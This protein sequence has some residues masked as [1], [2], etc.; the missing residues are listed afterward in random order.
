MAPSMRPV[1]AGVAVAIVIA[2]VVAALY[3]YVPFK[4]TG[5]STSSTSVTTQ[6]P[7][8]LQL[9]LSLNSTRIASGGTLGATVSEFNNQATT[10]NVTKADLWKVQGLSLGPCETEGYSIYPFGIAVYQG[11]YSSANVSQGKAMAIYPVVACPLMLRLVTGYLFQPMNDSAVILPSSGALPTSMSVTV[12]VSGEFGQGSL[13]PLAPGVYTV[14]AGD[15]WGSLITMQ[16][17]V[18]GGS[19]SSSTSGSRMNGTL[20]ALV[21]IGPIVPVCGVN[22]TPG[23]AASQYSSIKAVITPSSGGN[24]TL[25]VNWLSDGC[26]VSGRFQAFLAPGDYQLNL[27]NCSFMGCSSSLPKAFT[28]SP[29]Q[30]NTLSVSIDTGIR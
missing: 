4:T 3:V 21:T 7:N 23:P 13:Q 22:A 6:R 29:G 8:G 15:E 2:L 20:S 30:Q 11:A 10:N 12:R 9:R 19:T 26:N 1:V 25:P 17:T 14:V 18:E 24:I 5:S 28:I 16:F 27:T